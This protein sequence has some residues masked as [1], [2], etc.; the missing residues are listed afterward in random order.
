MLLLLLVVVLLVTPVLSDIVTLASA[1]N[2][3]LVKATTTTDTFCFTGGPQESDFK[4]YH[5]VT[6]F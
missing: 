3:A 1:T 4:F 6:A 5:K 2:I